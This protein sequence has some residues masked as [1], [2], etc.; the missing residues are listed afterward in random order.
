M[1][2]TITGINQANFNISED[3]LYGHELVV[4]LC[5]VSSKNIDI[6]TADQFILCKP[7]TFVNSLVILTFPRNLKKTFI[8]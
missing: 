3:E 2:I 1:Q 8:P 6:E 5:F 7:D 4:G